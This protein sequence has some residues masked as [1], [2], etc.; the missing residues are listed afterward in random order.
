MG[1]TQVTSLHPVRVDGDP[2]E[3][4]IVTNKAAPTIYYRSH[5]AVSSSLNDGSLA[6]NASVT[7]Y[8]ATWFISAAQTDGEIRV[9]DASYTLASVG[10]LT[11]V[12]GA[13][14]EADLSG[15]RLHAQAHVV[16]KES[17]AESG[18]EVYILEHNNSA[19]V[20]TSSKL[21]KFGEVVPSF[22]TWTAAAWAIAGKTTSAV[23]VADLI[24]GKGAAPTITFGLYPITLTS[25][26]TKQTEITYGAVVTNS[27]AKFTTPAAKTLAQV[28]SGAIALSNATGYSIGFTTSA[29]TLAESLVVAN[30]KLF[31]KN[32]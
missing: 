15:Y 30:V 22:F 21:A 7:L 12:S 14:T 6:E 10:S 8:G 27:A 11:K 4:I 28:T 2:R 24:N 20:L 19:P 31:V 23:L 26:T 9:E 16:L 25:E 3:P 13:N 18:T 1:N 5:E 32:A 17:L 29:A